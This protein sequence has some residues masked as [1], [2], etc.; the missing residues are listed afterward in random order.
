MSNDSPNSNKSKA[1]RKQPDLRQFLSKRKKLHE[2]ES[3]NSPSLS[4]PQSQEDDMEMGGS[5]TCNVPLEE[6]L[7]YDVELLPHDPRKRINIMD[8]PANERNAVRRGYILKK[9]C[10]PKTH[11]FPQRQVSGLRRFSVHWFK[12]W[13]WLEYSIE[14]DAAFCFVCYLFKNEVDSYSGG[15]AFVDG[16]FRAWNK[17]ERFEKHV[18]GINS[19]HNLAYEKYVNLRDGKKKSILNVF[20]NASEVIKSEYFIRLNASLTC[21]RFLLGQGLAFRGH[22]ESGESYNRGNFLELLKWLGEKVEEVRQH[23]LENAPK[24]CQMI[25]PSIQKDII[26]CCAKETTRCIIEEVGDDYFAILADESND[27]SQKEQLA[28]VLRFV[29]RDSGKVMERFLGIVHVGNTTALTLK[30]AIMSLLVEHSLSPSMIRGQGYD[31]ASNMKG[32]INGL[33][34]L[35]MNDTPSAYYVHCF[36]HQLQLTLVVIAKKNDSCG[37][38]F[39]ILANLLNVVGV[40]CKRR[41]M[42]RQDQA[43]EVARA[44]DVGDIVSGSGLNQEL[45]L[46]RP[47]DTR[48]S[49]YYKSIS[50]I[51]L[52]FPT[53]VKVLVHI[54]KHGVSEDKFKA[55]IVLGQL[56]SFDFVFIAH[57]MLTIFGYTNDLCVALQRKKQ[58]IVNAMELVT[59]TKL[60]LQKMREQGWDTLLNKVT[61]FCAKHGIVVP[62]M[63][64]PY[65]PQG[66]SRRFVEEATNEHHFRVEIFVRVIDL[67]L[68]EL[69]DRFNERNME[70]LICMA[71]L[72]PKDN[73]SSFDKDKVLKLAS[74]YPEE[75]SSFDLMALEC[76]L[77][78]FMENM[79]NDDRFQGINDLNSLS[80]MLVKTNKHKTFPLIHLLIKLMLILP[81]ATTSVERVFSA[82]TCVKNKLRNSMGDQLMND[83]LVTFIE[84]DVFL[85]VSDEKIVDR[86]QNMKTRRMKV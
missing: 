58:D 25:S 48:W 50:N 61:S 86:F 52:L 20:D 72:S 79:L 77:D 80:M 84:K 27:V 81:V 42:I 34:T 4:P 59:Y 43:Q 32:E 16:G 5:S 82:M 23:T 33:K 30:D 70:I 10:Q 1:T 14:K 44:L 19:V 3:N 51:I 21:L 68:Q 49:S 31:G 83:C 57:L 37:C 41:E 73:F 8:C 75:F 11:D 12:K 2:N 64:S 7:V 78:I 45:G 28:L 46:K 15:D 22:D 39:E 36:A 56:E 26:N 29:N 69:D 74:F 18:G 9:P 55:Q 85:R 62:T 47:G 54:G 53:I 6:N 71:C 76:H 17:P 13:D 35:I 65:V 60:V 40:S 63:D 66:R 67:H 38:L 24:N